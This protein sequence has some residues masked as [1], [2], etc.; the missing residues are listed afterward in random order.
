MREVA[1]GPPASAGGVMHGAG[2]K[3]G[4][5][6]TT[7]P[8]DRSMATKKAAH[9]F[10]PAELKAIRDAKKAGMSR[11]ECLKIM[12]D[13]AR[14]AALAE[15]NGWR[16]SELAATLAYHERRIEAVYGPAPL[17]TDAELCQAFQRVAEACGGDILQACR[18]CGEREV[19][20]RDGLVDSLPTYGGPKG[21]AIYKALV[22]GT[23]T[24]RDLDKAG[25]H[26]TWR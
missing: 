15:A 9:G 17:F 20:H 2:P 1:E 26:K 5:F 25:V 12:R 19:I 23:L 13:G 21:E 7:T 11:E 14:N 24:D 10:K 18:E 8:E 3:S 22:A 6:P 16:D 4:P